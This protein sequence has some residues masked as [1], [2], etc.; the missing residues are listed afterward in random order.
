VA[1]PA[2][3]LAMTSY[4]T[5]TFRAVDLAVLIV[6]ATCTYWLMALTAQEATHVEGVLHCINHFLQIPSQD[7]HTL[8][9]T[10]E[11][12]TAQGSQEI[13]KLHVAE[14]HTYQDGICKQKY[15]VNHSII[16]F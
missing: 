8:S 7:V 14:E 12:S 2:G 10:E 6:E 11:F 1:L 13:Q 5:N 3:Q 4:S 9:L 16:L 15:L